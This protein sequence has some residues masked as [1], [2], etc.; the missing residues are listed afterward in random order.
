MM[1]QKKELS[2]R[3]LQERRRQVSLPFVQALS[4]GAYFAQTFAL[5]A[6]PS[7]VSDVYWS[8]LLMC[9]DFLLVPS[10]AVPARCEWHMHTFDNDLVYISLRPESRVTMV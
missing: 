4:P 6:V 7:N 2:F 5:R 9:I 10:N 3:T 1:N 8:Y